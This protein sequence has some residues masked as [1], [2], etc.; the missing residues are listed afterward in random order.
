MIADIC[1]QVVLIDVMLSVK[2][3]TLISISGRGSAISSAKQ[4]KS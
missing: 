1:E 3:A 2:A 4:G